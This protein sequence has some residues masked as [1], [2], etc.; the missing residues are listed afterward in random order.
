MLKENSKIVFVGFHHS[1]STSVPVIGETAG[2][3]FYE[4]DIVTDLGA[5][6]RIY[7]FAKTLGYTYLM[8]SV[9][10]YKFACGESSKLSIYPEKG[11]I[12]KIGN[13]VIV[14]LS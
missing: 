6:K 5:N 10:D 4:W 14:R 13:I 12:R 11:S 2:Y 9:D 7:S 3:S 8:P 1:K